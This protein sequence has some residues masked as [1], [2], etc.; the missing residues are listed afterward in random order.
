MLNCK[1]TYSGEIILD[2]DNDSIADFK[3]NCPSIANNDQ[4]DSDRDGLR[5]TYVT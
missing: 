3:D 2:T 5:E 4:S 1:Y